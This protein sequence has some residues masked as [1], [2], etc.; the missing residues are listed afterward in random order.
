MKAFRFQLGRVLDLRA[1][2]LD[3]EENALKELFAERKRQE[4]VLADLRAE[5]LR[6]GRSLTLESRIDGSELSAL[7]AYRGHLRDREQGLRRQR[8]EHD[9]RIAGQ[10]GRVLEARKRVRLLEKLRD[11]RRS[12]WEHE[13]GRELEALAGEAFLARWNRQE[14]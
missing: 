2:Q 5:W 3:R 7:G 14:G 9:A 11:R 13:L 1:A 10:R 8:E 4:Q 6:S 12:S